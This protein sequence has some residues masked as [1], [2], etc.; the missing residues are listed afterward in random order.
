MSKYW[1]AVS[2]LT[3]LCVG[4]SLAFFI[5]Y[6]TGLALSV[7]GINVSILLAA[8]SAK[9]AAANFDKAIVVAC[10]VTAAIFHICSLIFG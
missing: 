2:V 10:L 8:L 5:N 7:T 6:P 4:I 9:N 3:I 1:I